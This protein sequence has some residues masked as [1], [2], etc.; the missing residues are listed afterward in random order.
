MAQGPQ[1]ED[2]HTR[3]A[4][5]FLEAY[6]RY[7]LAGEQGQVFW[8]ILR[9]TWGWRKKE[10]SIPLSQFVAATGLKKPV[11]CRALKALEE[12][13]LIIIKNVND[14]AKTYRIN[15]HYENWKPLT[16]K[17]TLSKML[18]P[19]HNNVNS[20]LT[21]LS[22]SKETNSKETNSKEN[23]AS[24]S[25]EIRLSKLLYSLMLCNNPK[26][27]KPNFQ[28]WAKHIDLAIRRDKRSPEEI[29][30]IIRFSQNH[31]FWF[32]NILSTKALRKQ[33]D[34]L[35]LEMKRGG[36]SKADRRIRNNLTAMREA[37]ELIND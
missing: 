35:L 11:V 5:E 34:R 1:L 31:D 32:K 33:F 15:K 28:N 23:F 21:F 36:Q 27:K 14:R 26:A 8:F 3:I 22:T 6:I 2:G 7:R 4:N 10:D 30:T 25:I 19:V 37:R 13:K 12:K 24:D 16:K 29:E 9:K 17:I 20:S 18:T